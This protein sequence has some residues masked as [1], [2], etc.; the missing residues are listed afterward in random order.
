LRFFGVAVG[1]GFSMSATHW[2]TSS[3]GMRWIAQ[4]QIR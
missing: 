3:A 2:S 1:S 4:Y